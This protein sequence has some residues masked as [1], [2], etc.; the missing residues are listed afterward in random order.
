LGDGGEAVVAL[1]TYS[2]H[3]FFATL[4]KIATIAQYNT[5]DIPLV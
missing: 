3:L 5:G 2:P 1:V 4:R